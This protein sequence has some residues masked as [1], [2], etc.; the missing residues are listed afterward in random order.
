M[1]IGTHR[2]G[3]NHHDDTTPAANAPDRD[4]TCRFLLKGTAGARGV[5]FSTAFGGDHGDSITIA[6]AAQGHW[7]VTAVGDRLPN[8]DVPTISTGDTLAFGEPR[9]WLDFTQVAVRRARLYS[10]PQAQAAT[11]AYL[12]K[13][14]VAAVLARSG[15]W[16]EIDYFARGATRVRW[17]RR[18]D[19]GAD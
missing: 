8:C 13:G 5:D 14:D 15:D 10:A 18:A 1:M 17:V 16:V 11:R 19:L 2:P 6:P 4:P 3:P 7:V 9:D 12:V